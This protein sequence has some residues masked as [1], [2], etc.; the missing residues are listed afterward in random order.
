MSHIGDL[1]KYE[2]YNTST[3]NF[4]EIPKEILENKNDPVFVQSGYHTIVDELIYHKNGWWKKAENSIT[5]KVT[6]CPIDI[7]SNYYTYYYKM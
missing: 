6:L 5:G 4:K 3:K 2:R 7:N 1:Y